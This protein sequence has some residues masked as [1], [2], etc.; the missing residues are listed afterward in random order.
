VASRRRATARRRIPHSV[1]PRRPRRRATPTPSDVVRRGWDRV[2]W[3]Y[4]PAARPRDCFGHSERQYSEWLRPLRDGLPAGSNVL[5]LGCGSGEPVARLLAPTFR[6]VGVDISA[7]QVRRARDAVPG[8]RFLR[9]DMTRVRFA[10]RSFDAVVA[11]YSLIHVPLPRQ[12]PLIRR[13]RRW[14]PDGGLFVAVLG[15]TAWTGREPDWLGAGVEMF[16][17]HADAATYR[18]WLVE[19]GF[20]I[21]SQAFVPEGHGGH[22]LFVARAIRRSLRPG[23]PLGRR[24]VSATR[25]SSR[26]LPPRRRDR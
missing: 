24:A 21:V 5:D 26:G 2:S 16:W 9:A 22:E 4:R 10:P 23:S 19:A 17:S 15:H 14:L 7:V 8:A 20:E 11:F 12:R 6:V 13:V 18:R 1:A 3:T 25:S